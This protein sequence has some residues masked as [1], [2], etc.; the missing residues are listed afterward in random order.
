VR[1]RG[2]KATWTW[3]WMADPCSIK[4]ETERNGAVHM[5]T[6]PI[7]GRTVE[8]NLQPFRFFA[9]ALI[10]RRTGREL[11][12]PAVHVEEAVFHLQVMESIYQCAEDGT[13]RSVT[14]PPGIAPSPILV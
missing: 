8:A 10:A 11:P 13:S 14:C 4:V 6:R 3:D 1:L 12:T 7:P 5:E 2:T 9:K